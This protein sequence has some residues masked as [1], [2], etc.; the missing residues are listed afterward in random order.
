MSKAIEENEW[1]VW[2]KSIIF[3]FTLEIYVYS[4]K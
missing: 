4:Q 3:Q 2:I 1:K